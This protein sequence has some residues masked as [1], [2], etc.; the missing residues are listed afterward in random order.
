MDRTFRSKPLVFVTFAWIAGIGLADRWAITPAMAGAMGLTLGVAALACRRRWHS[1]ALLLL[2]I[3]GLGLAATRLAM[4]PPRGDISA[5]SD[6]QVGISAVVETEPVLR[7]DRWRCMV[8]CL[9][10]IDAKQRYPVRG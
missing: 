8:D 2:G 4:I 9:A 5:W 1:L 3:A 6:R 10:V 7:C